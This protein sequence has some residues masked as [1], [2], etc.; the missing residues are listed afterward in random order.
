MSND[1]EKVPEQIYKLFEETFWQYF[2]YDQPPKLL[3]GRER[4]T[5]WRLCKAWDPPLMMRTKD[6]ADEM[7]R[8]G[9]KCL[10][11]HW[12][13]KQA[14][15]EP[16]RLQPNGCKVKP[17]DVPPELREGGKPDGEILT[18]PYLERTEKWYL[19]KSYVS[20][21]FKKGALMYRLKVGAAYAYKYTEVAALRDTLTEN[22]KDDR[23]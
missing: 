20:R 9:L 17:K 7:T 6:G 11:W 18:M 2:G 21:A 3:T 15:G 19:K 4:S 13:R 22:T 14:P 8:F 23:L 5:T 10:Y 12:L 16:K 1:F